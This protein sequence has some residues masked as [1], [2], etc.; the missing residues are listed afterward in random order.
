MIFLYFAILSF[1]PSIVWLLFFLKEDVRPEPNKTILK[2][3]I[4]G[5]I[6]TFPVLLI[7]IITSYI[8]RGMDIPLFA[9]MLIQV[10]FIAAVTEELVKY[11]VVKY[12]VLNSPECDEPV[13]IMIYAITAA[14]GFAALE[15]IL[16]LFPIKEF[17]AAVSVSTPM[18]I[19]NSLSINDAVIGSLIRFMSG[20]FLHALVSGIM[21]YYIAISILN[22][23]KRK[24][25]IAKG[26]AIAMLLHGLYN[27]SIIMSET[28][29][30][31]LSLAPVILITLF[32]V[33][34]LCFSKLRSMPSI[35]K[36][37]NDETRR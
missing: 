32:L 13:D 26:L 23:K 36:L 15:N 20:T 4:Y 25:L 35:C 33:V 31:F 16:F 6:S 28:N 8:L 14:M 30:W 24:I 9:I 12:S 19:D 1:L 17:L 21:G 11:M 10:V 3:F 7:G 27:S 2:V 5:M 34:F 37:E 18:L 29:E 22:D